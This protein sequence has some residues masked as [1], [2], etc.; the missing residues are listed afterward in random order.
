ML[1]SAVHKG[2]HTDFRGKISFEKKRVKIKTQKAKYYVDLPNRSGNT[3]L[4]LSL[5]KITA[6]L[7]K[8]KEACQSVWVTTKYSTT[9]E[10]IS[11]M[12][13]NVALVQKV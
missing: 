6:L 10:I 4:T 7:H 1:T 11:Y 2:S 13:E 12:E 9:Q 3:I 8:G 5:N